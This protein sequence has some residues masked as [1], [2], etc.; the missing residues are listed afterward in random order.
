V[1]E[2]SKAKDPAYKRLILFPLALFYMAL[3]VAAGWPPQ[4]SPRTRVVGA[5]QLAAN[6][7]LAQLAIMPG[8]GVFTGDTHGERTATV[9]SCFKIVGYT[10]DRAPVVLFD[11]MERCRN[12]TRSV[13]KPHARWFQ[14]QQLRIAISHLY[15]PGADLDRNRPPLNVLFSI[16]DYY[17][18]RDGEG[19]YTR[20]VVT[21][22]HQRLDLDT[23]ERTDVTTLD[24]VH[25]CR[26]GRWDVVR[27]RIEPEGDDL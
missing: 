2:P 24:G 25:Q 4:L 20:L 5:I 23:G 9:R 22:R 21:S 1:S 27:K 19:K 8:V 11:T 3:L 15:T 10:P 7:T 16:C 14:E 26:E 17:C 13:F 18:H 12:E 6:H